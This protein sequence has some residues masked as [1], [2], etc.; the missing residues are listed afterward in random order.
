MS[1]PSSGSRTSQARNK[2]DTDSKQNYL[3]HA[4]FLLGI[5]FNPEDGGKM[6]L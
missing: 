6:F 4:G 1:P 2:C 5:F 3:L